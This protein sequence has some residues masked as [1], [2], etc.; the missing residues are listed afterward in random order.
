MRTL[1]IEKVNEFRENGPATACKYCDE[2]TLALYWTKNKYTDKKTYES[3]D[4]LDLFLNDY[5]RY[6]DEINGNE[7]LKKFLEKN[8]VVEKFILMMF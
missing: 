2:C 6:D 4:C 3:Y 1:T 8:L 5:D 7:L